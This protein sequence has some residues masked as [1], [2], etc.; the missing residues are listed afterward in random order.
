MDER[1]EKLTW[2]ASHLEYLDCCP[3]C[4]STNYQKFL[5]GIKDIYFNV[6]SGEWVVHKCSDCGV[7][8]LNPRPIEESIHKAYQ[9]YYTHSD[10]DSSR[11]V[12]VI[13]KNIKQLFNKWLEKKKSNKKGVIQYFGDALMPFFA[14]KIRHL[15][16]SSLNQKQLLDVGCGN[17]DFL[18]MA[19]EMGWNAEGIDFDEAAVVF[20][21]SRGL[22]VNLG[23]ADE[24]FKSQKRYDYITISH[25]IEHVYDPQSLIARL[26]DLLEPGGTLWLETPNINSFGVRF[27][28]LK[29]RGLEVPRHIFLFNPELMNRMLMDAGFVHISNHYHILSA[30]FMMV[31]SARQ[32]LNEHDG[33]F[34]VFYRCGYLFLGIFMEILSFFCP[35]K[36]EFITITAKKRGIKKNAN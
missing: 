30:S 33:M 11:W 35:S 1:I 3:I 27:F 36:R 18:L 19:Q 8:F 23:N 25:V 28:D 4:N 16:I 13:K 10:P 15:P 29:W 32:V 22:S 24:V 26:Y 12:P 6:V 7:G 14:A 17:G 34:K 2:S 21:L 20:A 9:T 31:S 5:T